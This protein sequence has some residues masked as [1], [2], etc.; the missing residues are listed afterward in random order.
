MIRSAAADLAPL[1]SLRSLMS[2]AKLLH[3]SLY[4]VSVPFFCFILCCLWQASS[5]VRDQA[6]THAAPVHGVFSSRVFSLLPVPH[7]LHVELAEALAWTQ[8]CYNLLADL[9][10][11]NPAA[12]VCTGLW[13]CM[14]HDRLWLCVFITASLYYR[15][16]VQIFALSVLLSA[17]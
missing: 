9:S 15:A 11:T 1:S 17:P 3:T 10:S 4:P 2:L 16:N 12:Q 8:T 13:H 14:T 7:L 5:L 6:L